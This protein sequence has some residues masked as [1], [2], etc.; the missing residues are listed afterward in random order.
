MWV[1]NKAFRNAYLSLCLL[2]FVCFGHLWI[3]RILVLGWILYS[4]RI[5]NTAR[6]NATKLV[7]FLGVVCLSQ[8]LGIVLVLINSWSMAFG[9]VSEWTSGLVEAWYHPFICVLELLPRGNL[10]N[11]SD[12]YLEMCLIPVGLILLSAA[13]WI[14]M[15]GV[16]P[17]QG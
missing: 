7:T 10:G 4:A 16:N 15:E 14:I 13:F 3:Q 2:S 1:I 5:A 12:M 6:Q 8:L 11:W 9:A 17:S